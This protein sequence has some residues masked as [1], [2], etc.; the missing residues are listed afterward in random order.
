M[1]VEKVVVM[2]KGGTA[3]FEVVLTW[4]LEVLAILT[5]G[6]KSVHPLKGGGG[7][8][9][10]GVGGKQFRARIFFIV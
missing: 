5:G 9:L 3:S 1:G 6:T 4:E 2:P 10:E 8:S 7:G